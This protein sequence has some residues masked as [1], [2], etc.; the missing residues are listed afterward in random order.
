VEKKGNDY[1]ILMGRPER[2]RPVGR[3]RHR[4]LD[5]IKLDCRE[6]FW[7]DVAQDRG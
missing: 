1:R 3:P 2:K 4:Q 6:I 5:N 7:G